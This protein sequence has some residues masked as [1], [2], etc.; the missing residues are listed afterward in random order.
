MKISNGGAEIC[1]WENKHMKGIIILLAS[2]Y[3]LFLE[4]PHRPSSYIRNKQKKQFE[5]TLDDA[6]NSFLHLAGNEMKND[7]S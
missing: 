2:M 3:S 4:A 1:V 7:G 5:I 6:N